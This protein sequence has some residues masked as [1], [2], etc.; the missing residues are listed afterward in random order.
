ME[1]EDSRSGLSLFDCATIVAGSMI[2]SGIF[3]VSADITRQVGS[4]AALLA[5]W[6]VA[7][8]MTIAGALTY[9]ELA[10]MMPQAGGQYVFIREAYGGALAFAFGWTL[11]LVIQTGTIAAVAVAFARFAGVIW[12]VLGS[13]IFLG[14]G[15]VGVSGERIGAI[16]VITI[17]TAVNLSGLRAGAYV[18][19]AFT[20]AKVISLLMIVI[21]CG[22]IARNPAAI[23]LNF[24]NATAWLGSQRF[25]S[26]W[27]ATFGAAMVGALFSADAWGSVTFAASEARAARRDLPRALALGTGVVITLYVLTNVAYLC[28][29]PALGQP[30]AF[31][32]ERL[33]QSQVFLHGIAGAEDGRVATVVMRL[34]WGQAGATL[35]A[36]LVMVSTFG[37]ANGLILTGARVL[38]AMADDRLFFVAA[39]R[40]NRAGVPAVA[41]LMQGAWAALLTLS[42]TYADLLDYV[43]FAQLLF[44]VLTVGAVFIFRA[45]GPEA[46]PPDQAYRTWGYPV[47]PAAYMVVATALMADL[48]VVK[49]GYTWPGLLIALSGLPLYSWLRRRRV[50]TPSGL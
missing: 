32:I 46:E 9:G 6:I 22:V 12:P 25:S 5:V 36:M 35:T 29:L 38:Y 16:L 45:R 10:A 17:L 20:T 42:G 28:Q 18:Q 27:V 49:P 19:N 8:L 11:L 13:R 37:C 48:L 41:L 30:D 15:P 39:R 33:R 47:V 24:G 7:G 50:V 26:P 40:L 3:I 1:A 14:F 4:P 21:V 2:G 43:I 23:S 34:V 31:G 44:Y